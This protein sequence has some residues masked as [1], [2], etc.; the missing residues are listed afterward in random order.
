[1][2]PFAGRSWRSWKATRP[3]ATLAFAPLAAGAAV[4]LASGRPLVLGVA[5]GESLP[6]GLPVVEMAM[7]LPWLPAVD[8]VV[9]V[10]TVGAS[11]LGFPLVLEG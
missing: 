3:F 8:P 4:P 2:F 7:L 11:P 10:A 1:V 6:Q 5:L 9:F